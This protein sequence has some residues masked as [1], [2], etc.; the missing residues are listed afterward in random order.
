[1]RLHPITRLILLILALRV[2]ADL[3]MVWADT[4][5][6]VKMQDDPYGLSAHLIATHYSKSLGR[7]VE[8]LTYVIGA[9]WVEGLARI[10]AALKDGRLDFI[11]G[12]PRGEEP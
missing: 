12:A 5:V 11:V 4:T 6:V 9:V 1:M 7:V 2:G 3:L 10:W 8:S